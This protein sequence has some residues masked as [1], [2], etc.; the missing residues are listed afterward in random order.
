MWLL[1]SVVADAQNEPIGLDEDLAASEGAG[2]ESRAVQVWVPEEAFVSPSARSLERTLDSGPE[3]QRV[4]PATVWT[5]SEGERGFQD[6]GGSEP[7]G[8]PFSS[9][10]SDASTRSSVNF[11]ES[12]LDFFEPGAIAETDQRDHF[13]LTLGST[14]GYDDNVLLSA[15]DPIGSG[16]TG[17]NASLLY[18]F[19]T[20]RLDIRTALSAG[21]TYY[22]SRPDDDS[23]LNADYSI[24]VDYRA[25]RRLT[26]TSSLRLL[27]LSQP[28]PQIAGG[29]SQFQGDY[30]VTDDTLAAAYSLTPTWLLRL[31]YQFNALRYTDP[32]INFG[33]GFYQQV[34]ALTLERQLSTRTSVFAE[35]RYNPLV[36]YEA[37]TGSNGQILTLGFS[38]L[39]TPQVRWNFQF[40]AE[41]RELTD[42]SPDGPS[43]YIGPFLETDASYRF[44]PLSAISAS[45]RFGTEPSG[46]SAL[47]IT[48]TLRGTLSINHSFTARLTGD[49]GVV[50]VSQR[51]DLPGDAADLTQEVYS[52][53]GGL[54]F[55]LNPLLAL[56]ANYNYDALE[57]GF[58]FSSY[59]RSA[60]SLGIE[61]VF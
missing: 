1:V 38:Q 60:S 25:N 3:A 28:D 51:S 19:G 29:T 26:I 61:I 20:E 41:Q 7:N 22:D 24:N 9:E 27:F 58:D 16:T 8:V 39:V 49:F 36:Y 46:T 43:S 15:Q 18:D 42:P 52:F 11:L 50:Y 12:V 14:I 44:A 2:G 47:S 32:A 10:S 23:D 6:R 17:I 5:V 31:R 45:V 21:F 35:Y 40:G 48:Q 59:T 30:Y 57:T 4:D 53:F 56:R 33:L 13:R 55:R 37:E 54:R 34:F